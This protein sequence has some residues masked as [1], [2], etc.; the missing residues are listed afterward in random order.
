MLPKNQEAT[1]RD[2]REVLIHGSNLSGKESHKTKYRDEISIQYLTEIRTEYNKWHAANMALVGPHA[3]L[4]YDDKQI[5]TRNLQ[6]F[7]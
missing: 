4:S 2:D 1:L 7:S 6:K 5:I 3:A